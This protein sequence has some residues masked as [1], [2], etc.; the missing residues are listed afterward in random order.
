MPENRY[1]GGKELG[2]RK[3]KN[4]Q[5]RYRDSVMVRGRKKTTAAGMILYG[6]CILICGY[7]GYLI[8][9]IF[10]KESVQGFDDAVLRIQQIVDN[11]FSIAW[12]NG[13]V[14]FI[15]IYAGMFVVF[16]VIMMHIYSR[17]NYMPDVLWGSSQWGDVNAINRTTDNIFNYEDK[18]ADGHSIMVEI[19][20][21]FHRKPRKVTL[22]TYNMRLSKNLY[23]S[24]DTRYTDLN[25]NI[26]IVGGSGAGKTFRF[27]KPNI[28]SG[29]SC[30]FIVTDPKGELERDTAGFFD[31]FGFNVKVVD[32]RNSYELLKSTHY[33][34]FVYLRTDLDVIKLI[35][36]LISNTTPKGASPS[37]PFWEKAEGMYHQAVFHYVWKI[38]VYCE[39]TGKIEHNM[40]AVMWVVNHTEIIEDAQGNRKP[41]IVDTMFEKLENEDPN[42][43]AVIFWNNSMGG[44]ADT[45]RSIIIS[46]KAR[47]AP[48][49][50][51]ALLNFLWDDEIDIENI[52]QERTALFCKIPDNDKTYNFL[53]GILYTQCFQILYDTADNV[54]D[55]ALP[56]HVRFMFDEFAN[57]AL[58]DGFMSI[59][60]TE[61]SRNMSS[62]IIIQNMGQIKGLFKDDW[63]SI[64][65]NTDTFIYLGG[66]EQST[67]KFVSEQLGKATIDK[68]STSR[69][70]GDKQG[71]SKSDDSTGR[72]LLFSDEV[73]KLRRDKCII[74]INGKDPIIDYKVTPL[75]EP[76]W[77][78]MVDTSKTY[79]FDARIKRHS[80][81]TKREMG[82]LSEQEVN[83]LKMKDKQMEKRY[84]YEKKVAGL[85]GED[86]TM[87][88]KYRPNVIELTP[89]EV[90]Y[91]AEHS[92]DYDIESVLKD[93][94][95][96]Q[97]EQNRQHIYEE[98]QEKKEILEKEEE[99]RKKDAFDMGQLNTSAEAEV[100]LRL[101]KEGYPIRIIKLLLQLVKPP[102][103][104]NIEKI[105]DQFSSDMEYSMVEAAVSILLDT[106]EK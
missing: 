43:S 19:P 82:V 30:S 67:H 88:E 44:A 6:I 68:Y 103:N 13:W 80:L 78:I 64:C 48:L 46:A 83:I 55:G 77:K 101:N 16:G 12:W 14:S 86:G 17:R 89:A 65:G 76:L 36:N 94:S 34:P 79:V 60:S 104:Y 75:N 106:Y 45:V 41:C 105:L 42:H 91:L 2:R 37:D 56:V 26:L 72:E 38:G 4:A 10:D 54:Y 93:I 74:L 102:V 28:M 98:V 71:S 32:L 50:D 99:E 24:F 22:N 33:N 84:L 23:L 1:R 62:T 15:A 53:I 73:R 39:K 7:V 31:Y 51:E 18:D 96:A 97:I 90:L 58:P 70:F 3:K 85:L 49:N 35:S 47:L 87:P 66:N 63:E 5:K 95:E 27:V 8:G 40:W 25:N 81:K 59:L 57:V 29:L 61:R 100:F 21:K 11:P 92:D 52:G 9:G 69:N 20:R